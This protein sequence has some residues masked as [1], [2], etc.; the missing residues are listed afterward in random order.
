M[1]IDTH[2]DDNRNKI[3]DKT[4]DERQHSDVEGQSGPPGNKRSFINDMLQN[5][6]SSRLLY[7]K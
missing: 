5:V 1:D 2:N 6:S 4:K 7:Y 3:I